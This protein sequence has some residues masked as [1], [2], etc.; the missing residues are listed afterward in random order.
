[1]IDVDGVPLAYDDVGEGPVVLLLHAGV[2]DRR[3]WRHQV[4]A[5][6]ERHRILNVDLPGYGDSGQPRDGYANHDAVAGLLTALDV[7]Q[8]A[9][10]GC[11]LGGAVALDI[12]LAFPDR[13]G[14]LALFAPA[15]SGHRW[16]EEFQELAESHFAGIDEEDVEAVARAEV[17]LW[18]VGPDREPGDLDPAFLRFALELNVSAVRAEAALDAVSSVVLTPP[19][20][21]RLGEI[22]VRTLVMVGAADVAEMHRLADQITATVPRAQR[23]P[24]VPDTAHLLP[25][26]R[27]DLV[28]PILQDFLT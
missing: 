7:G 17:D 22:G 1:M 16:S 18:A 10:V 5:L 20:I 13:V 24:D 15:V 8:A 4:T 25:L 19:A 14:A 12:A 2:A 3:M 6:R 27:P 28:N 21:G 23:V 26:E 11:S 9:L